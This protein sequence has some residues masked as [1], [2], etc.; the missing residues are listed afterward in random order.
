MSSFPLRPVRRIWQAATLL[1]TLAILGCATGT[2]DEL[3][4]D[5]GK[6]VPVK[7]TVK[8]K[9]KPLRGVVVTFLPPKWSAS[10][11]ETDADG[12]Y[13]LETARKPGALP[14]EYKVAISYLVSADGQPQGLAPRSSMSPSLGMSTAQEKLPAE[15]SDLGRTT[16]KATVPSGGGTFD[17]DL[18]IDL[19]TK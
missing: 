18:P 19:D 9:G 6:L 8:I 11:G 3:P 5:F 17:F 15:F 1:S 7:G 10:N 12:S 14:G 13:T 16:L 2:P 4:P